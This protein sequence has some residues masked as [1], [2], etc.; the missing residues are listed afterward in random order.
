M[1]LRQELNAVVESSAGQLSSPKSLSEIVIAGPSG[2]LGPEESVRSA[3]RSARPAEMIQRVEEV[4]STSD[5]EEYRMGPVERTED[6][7][8]RDLVFNETARRMSFREG[9]A[10]KLFRSWIVLA[11]SASL[12]VTVAPYTVS[13]AGERSLLGCV[14]DF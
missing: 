12:V 1:R 8:Q 9:S 6:R 4:R 14:E 11:L 13:L 3:P 5:E 7:H 2:V 10:A